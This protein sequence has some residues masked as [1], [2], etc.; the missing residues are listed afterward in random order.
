VVHYSHFIF[1]TS[2]VV[3]SLKVSIFKKTIDCLACVSTNSSN[4]YNVMYIL[5]KSLKLFV[6]HFKI[7]LF[8]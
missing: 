7:S 3:Y 8:V 1:D 2:F 6:V 5:F 4:R